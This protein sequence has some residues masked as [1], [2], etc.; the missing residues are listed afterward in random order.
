MITIK[1]IAQKA[2]VSIATVSRV[3]NK[4]K[5]VSPDIEKKVMEVVENII[6]VPTVLHRR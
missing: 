3:L 5:Y 4:S 2:G 6:I 1:F